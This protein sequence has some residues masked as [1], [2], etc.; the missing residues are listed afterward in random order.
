MLKPVG[1]EVRHKAAFTHT[2]G[3]WCVY[4]GRKVWSLDS[5]LAVLNTTLPLSPREA[6]W[7]CSGRAEG[8]LKTQSNESCKLC[9]RAKGEVNLFGAFPP[10]SHPVLAGFLAQEH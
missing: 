8:V 4:T 5:V 1:K 2:F 10:S 3:T 7:A 9:L 6:G